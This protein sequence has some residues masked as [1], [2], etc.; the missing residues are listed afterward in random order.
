MYLLGNSTLPYKKIMFEIKKGTKKTTPIPVIT[1]SCLK[2][3]FF[4]TNSSRTNNFFLKKELFITTK[5]NN[6]VIKNNNT[7]KRIFKFIRE[8]INIP[9]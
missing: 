9:F 3:G 6:N 8:L 4:K 7:G 1:F 2:L 5:I